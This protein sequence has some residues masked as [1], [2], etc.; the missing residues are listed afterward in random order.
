M[1]SPRLTVT[2]CAAIASVG[3]VIDSLEMLGSRWSLEANFD[4][5]V[6]EAGHPALIKHPRLASVVT[7]LT[8]NSGLT[9][10]LVAR[11]SGAPLAA[12]MFMVDLSGAVVLCLLVTLSSALLRLRLTYGLDG[13][14]QMQAVVWGGL[15][16]YGIATVPWIRELAL[17]FI[18]A[19]LLLSYLTAGLAKV[20]SLQWRDGR[21]ITGILST[22]LHGNRILLRYIGRR[23]YSIV[24]AWGVI[25]FEIVGPAA[26]VMSMIGVL[27]VCVLAVFFH[28]GIAFAMRLN[29]FVWAFLSAL[30]PLIYTIQLI[31]ERPLW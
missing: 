30:P 9:S 3:I 26:A 31:H 12:L 17:G 15:T 6:L 10:L 11:V 23:P 24:L 16:L 21:A 22:Q 14:D 13:A 27:V 1:I 19:Q 20:M 8:T 7:A 18:A 28:L 4:W 5:V 29:G 2:A 25:L